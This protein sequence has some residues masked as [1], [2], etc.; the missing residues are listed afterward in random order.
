MLSEEEKKHLE[1]IKLMQERKDK[2]IKALEKKCNTLIVISL[3]LGLMSFMFYKEYKFQYRENGILLNNVYEIV[4]P[5]PNIVKQLEDYLQD[6]EQELEQRA[7]H[8]KLY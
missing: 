6:R 4:K 5:Y 8:Y 3:I 2:E 1:N 7:E